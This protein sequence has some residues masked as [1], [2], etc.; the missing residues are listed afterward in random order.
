MALHARGPTIQQFLCAS[1]RFQLGQAPVKAVP[2]GFL[3]EP[4]YEVGG[5]LKVWPG[6][7]CDLLLA[8]PG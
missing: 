4:E 2:C 1:A 5:L 6:M 7:V 8:V 3:V